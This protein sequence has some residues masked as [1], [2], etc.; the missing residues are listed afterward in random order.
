MANN[1]ISLV[2][3]NVPN[4]PKMTAHPV[5][6]TCGGKVKDTNVPFTRGVGFVVLE[7][8][9]WYQ[10]NWSLRVWELINYTQYVKPDKKI[11]G[12]YRVSQ[13]K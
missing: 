12:G 7:D 3:F 9:S 5:C 4:K 8:G 11:I 10:Y 1:P 2:Q 6:E 13:M